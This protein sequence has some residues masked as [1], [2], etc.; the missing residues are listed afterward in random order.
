[1]RRDFRAELSGVKCWDRRTE[2]LMNRYGVPLEDA[3][4]QNREE[5]IG[6]CEWI[7]EHQISSYLEIGIWTGGLITWLDK[8][9]QFKR[10]F[11]CDLGY[12]EQVGF[13][14]RL[15]P[16]SVWFKGNSRSPRYRKWRETLGQIDLVM[17][18]ADHSYEGV[19]RDFE[20]NS[21]FDQRF[22]A[23]HDITGKGPGTAGVGR[24]WEE[25]R[26]CTNEIVRPHVEL[27]LDTSTMGIGIWWPA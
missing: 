17:I 7:E 2:E 9:F 19:K 3:V 14:V 24:F 21:R 1:M 12:A 25:L 11:A 5:L 13:T 6:F 27:G 15:P 16:H 10:V 20:I 26:G 8:L 23:F 18:D 22:I 4:L